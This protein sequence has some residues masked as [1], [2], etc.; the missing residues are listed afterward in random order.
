[1]DK[2][3]VL[4]KFGYSVLR[5]PEK[6]NLIVSKNVKEGTLWE[7]LNIYSVARYQKS[8]LEGGPFGDIKNLRKVS[9]PK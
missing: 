9:K 8:D 4:K 7:F 6:S 2:T 1:M 5:K 3:P